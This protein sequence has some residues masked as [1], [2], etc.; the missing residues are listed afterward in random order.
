M[1]EALPAHR[2]CWALSCAILPDLREM[3]VLP[4][5]PIV[6]AVAGAVASQATDRIFDGLAFLDHLVK[7]EPQGAA[8][9][10]AE[11][12]SEAAATEGAGE[13]LS[14]TRLQLDSV[15]ARIHQAIHDAL[16]ASGVALEGPLQLRLDGGQWRVQGHSQDR[17]VEEAL[18]GAPEVSGLFHEARQL[19]LDA[20]QE[21]LRRQ[22]GQKDPTDV[23]DTSRWQSFEADRMASA[24][25]GLF[26]DGQSARPVFHAN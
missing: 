26:I 22:F 8:P 24:G 3:S 16:A 21:D 18:A 14:A 12:A 19:A 15:L 9:T 17:Q 20:R 5:L 7:G 1:K 25:F 10:N 13:S 6:T 2:L 11:G 23:S 4:L